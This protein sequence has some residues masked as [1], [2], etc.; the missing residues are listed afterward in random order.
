MIYVYVHHLAVYLEITYYKSTIIENKFLK[1]AVS[2]TSDQMQRLKNGDAGEIMGEKQQGMGS[3]L[4]MEK[5]RMDNSFT[6]TAWKAE[7]MGI[8]AGRQ[9]GI[10]IGIKERLCFCFLR[11]IENTVDS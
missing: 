3:N 11:Y 2:D 10:V 5:E 4:Q 7:Y 8:N 1:I 9:D 6:I